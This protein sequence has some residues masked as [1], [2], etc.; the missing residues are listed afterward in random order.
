MFS[1]A[2]GR[3]D[4]IKFLESHVKPKTQLNTDAS[5]IYNGVEKYFLVSHTFDIHKKFEFTNTSE[6]EGMFEVLRTFIRRMYIMLQSKSFQ[7]I[8]WNFTA[9]FPDL[10]SSNL[11]AIAC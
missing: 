9:D 4:A 10:K 8:C 1:D 2:P 7:N 6:I 5:S 11:L 3:I